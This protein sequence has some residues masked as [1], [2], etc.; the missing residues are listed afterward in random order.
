VNL[1]WERGH[2]PLPV[3][4]PDGAVVR[5]VRTDGA[6][7]LAERDDWSLRNNPIDGDGTPPTDADSSTD[8]RRWFV[9]NHEPLCWDKQPRTWAELVDQAQ[10]LIIFIAVPPAHLAEPV[11][12]PSRHTGER[13][14]ADV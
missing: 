11:P 8:P 5:I 12:V 9:H 1:W 3:E 7:L 4:P 14:D 13:G 10:R 6:T 2:Q